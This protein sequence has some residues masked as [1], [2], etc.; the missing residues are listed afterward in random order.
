M[1][2]NKLPALLYIEPN[3][4]LFYSDSLKKVLVQDFPPDTVSD[5]DIVNKEKFN[6]ILN[7]FIQNALQKGT[8]ELTL[9]FSQ[10]T[11]FEKVLVPT[12]SKDID[13]LSSEFVGL[14]PFEEVLSKSYKENK[15]VKIVGIN[16]SFYEQI[17]DC[18]ARNGSITTLVL[19]LSVILEKN[20]E[21]ASNL[22]LSLITTKVDSLKAFNIIDYAP[23]QK[24][25]GTEQHASKNKNFRTYMLLGVFVV[26]LIIMLIFG[27]NTFFS[28][29]QPSKTIPSKAKAVPTV[30]PENIT[31]PSL[32][33]SPSIGTPSAPISSRSSNF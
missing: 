4:L 29:P 18:F 3:R 28:K 9:V 5:L 8:F 10:Q 23:N 2:E 1:A 11:Y 21:L 27:Y 13:A 31:Q 30:Q 24:A 32:V 14:I 16:K 33:P 20:P 12:I 19:P 26:L 25:Q 15:S 22:D 7:F 6:Q 17:A